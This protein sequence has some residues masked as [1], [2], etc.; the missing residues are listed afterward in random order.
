MITNTGSI[1]RAKPKWFQQLLK[2]YPWVSFLIII[3]LGGLIGYLSGFL[4]SPIYEAKAVLT[5]NID[6]QENRPIITEIMVDSQ[7]NYIGELMYNSKIIDPLLFQ[8]AKSGNPLKLEDLESM[9]SIERQL[10]NTIIKVR[11]KDPEIAARIATNWARIA[12]ETLTEAKLHVLATS[13]A[14][15]QLV[16]IET[17]FPLSPDAAKDVPISST[18]KSFCEGLSYQSAE[19]KLKEATKILATEESMT[20][21]LTAYINVSQLLP[22]SVP[23]IPTSNNQGMMTLSG[24]IIGIIIGII[25]VDIR[26]INKVDEN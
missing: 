16:I 22:A 6:L 1:T 26:R 15:Q 18:E 3:V 10:M 5:T 21:G 9:A 11:G 24:M 19:I 2:N 14:N 20:L 12:F 13:E 25:L 8:E 7:L 23:T 17:C 4:L